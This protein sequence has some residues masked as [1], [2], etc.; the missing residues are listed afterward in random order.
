MVNVIFDYNMLIGKIIEKYGTR[1][2]FAKAMDLSEHSMSRKL[3]SQ[4]PFTQ[5][6]ISKSCELLEIPNTEIGT[7]FFRAK[8]Q[9]IEHVN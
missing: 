4:V 7:Y 3:N 1:S 5:P 8:V 2:K 9:K 6:E